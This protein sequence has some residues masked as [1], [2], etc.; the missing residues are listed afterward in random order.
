MTADLPEFNS[1]NVEAEIEKIRP[2]LQRDGGDI[3]F[4]GIDGKTVKVKLKGACAGCAMATVTLQ[5]TVER[6]LK[7]VFPEIEKVQNVK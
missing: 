4:V 3:E 6:N 5:W 2:A 7:S 1:E